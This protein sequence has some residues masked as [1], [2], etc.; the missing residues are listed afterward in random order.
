MVVLIACAWGLLGAAAVEAL[1]L[2]KAI[3]RIHDFPWRH[4]DEPPLGPYLLSVF[5]RLA[6]GVGAAAACAASGQIAGPGGAIAAGYAAPKIFE[7]LAR[8]GTSEPEI[9]A[10]K[11]R[12]K[13]APNSDNPAIDSDGVIKPNVRAGD[14][15]STPPDGGVLE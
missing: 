3:H 13:A 5:I 2:Y 9:V 6:L 12:K 14:A 8:L 15:A 7:Q 4:P 11:P 1:D 10:E